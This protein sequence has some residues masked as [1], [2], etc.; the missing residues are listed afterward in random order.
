V[1]ACR[2]RGLFLRNA[3]AMSRHLGD[4]SIRIA[5]KDQRTNERMVEILRSLPGKPGL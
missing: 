3:R 2:P 5:V 1:Q 4:R